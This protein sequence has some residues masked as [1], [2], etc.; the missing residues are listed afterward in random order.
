MAAGKFPGIAARV[1]VP[2][3]MPASDDP[4]SEAN[5]FIRRLATGRTPVPVK[6]DLD[7]QGG[8]VIRLDD[9]T[10]I[11]YRPPGLASEKTAPTT[12]SVDIDSPKIK[13][14]NGGQRL[15]LKFPKK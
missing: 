4:A 8:Y 7:S 13:A 3:T 14:M 9:G 11:T 6:T 2:R 5:K 10:Y 15:K 12:A 1:G